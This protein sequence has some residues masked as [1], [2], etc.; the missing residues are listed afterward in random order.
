MLGSR[1]FGQD[2][3]L[4]PSWKEKQRK[5]LERE[6]K[7]A[8]EKESVVRYDPHYFQ[9]KM[10]LILSQKEKSRKKARGHKKRLEVRRNPHLL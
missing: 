2:I 5:E 8:T 10:F 7:R 1:L 4:T 6:G 9:Q 3:V